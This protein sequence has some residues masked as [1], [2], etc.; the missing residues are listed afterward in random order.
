MRLD[1]SSK[2]IV[3]KSTIIN[4]FI[5]KYNKIN[6]IKL[7]K[8]EVVYKIEINEGDSVK[9]QL[10]GIGTVLEIDG[11]NANVFFKKVGSK[12]LNIAFAPLEKIE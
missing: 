8:D 11:D 4:L 6:Q 9:H 10:F 5:L 7:N 3:I 12:K 2:Y 1:S